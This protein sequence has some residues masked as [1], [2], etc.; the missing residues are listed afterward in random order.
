MS[1]AFPSPASPTLSVVRLS[2]A[3][4]IPLRHAVLWPDRPPAFVVL[5][6]DGLPS[7]IHLGL[8]LASP[9][10]AESEPDRFEPV[11]ILTLVP[12][13]FPSPTSELG[14]LRALRVRKFATALDYQGHGYGTQLLSAAFALADNDDGS[15]TE[16]ELVWCDARAEQERWY[17]RRGMRREG[18]PFEKEGRPY[19]RMVRRQLQPERA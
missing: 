14:S 1:R 13:Q 4:T 5:P 7:T 18:E 17:E 16:V 9:S 10:R 19:V 6:E 2:A 15:G 3:R 8:A 12:T 11:S